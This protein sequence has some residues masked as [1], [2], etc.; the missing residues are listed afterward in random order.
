MVGAGPSVKPCSFVSYANR[1]E[2]GS[3]VNVAAHLF[4]D[5]LRDSLVVYCKEKVYGSIP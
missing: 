1:E 3:D 2:T 4:L 5:V